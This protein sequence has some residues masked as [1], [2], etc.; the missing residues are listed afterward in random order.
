MAAIADEVPATEYEVILR[1]ADFETF[2]IH[3]LEPV[4]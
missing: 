2:G 1:D 4:G 3:E